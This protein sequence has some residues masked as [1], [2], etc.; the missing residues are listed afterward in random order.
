MVVRSLRIEYEGAV[1]HVTCQGNEQKTIFKDDYDKNKFLELSND[2]LKTYTII[3]YCYVLMNNHFHLFLET[4]LSNLSEF[5][6][7]FNITSL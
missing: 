6:R 7:W 5:K 3:L 2:G 4:P 1:Y